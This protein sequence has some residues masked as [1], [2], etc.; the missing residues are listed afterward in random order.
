[1][2]IHAYH[3]DAFHSGQNRRGMP[4][5]LGMAMHIGHFAGI[6]AAQPVA[7]GSKSIRVGGRSNAGE[8]EAELLSVPFQSSLKAVHPMSI[9]GCSAGPDYAN[10]LVDPYRNRRFPVSPVLANPVRNGFCAQW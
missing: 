3:D 2:V 6:V 8:I 5:R 7:Q 1:M 10:G 9:A 4:P